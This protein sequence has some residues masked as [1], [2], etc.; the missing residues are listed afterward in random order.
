MEIINNLQ[1]QFG[2]MS[3]PLFICSALTLAIILERLL[4]VAL[5][6]S[7]GSKAIYRLLKEQNR[8][9]EQALTLFCKALSNKRPLLNKGIAMLIGHRHFNK[10]LRE[11]AAAIWLNQKRVQ[12]RSGL[13]LLALIG[14]IS[15]LLGLL[16]TVLGLIDMFKSV[17]ASTG[18]ITPNDLATGLGLAMRTTAAGLMVALPAISAA[19]LLG[20]W[21]DGVVRKLE[22][23]MNYCNLWLDGIDLSMQV[24]EMP[25]EEKHQLES[26]L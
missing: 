4:Q 1:A 8:D 2:L 19:Q 24:K 18:A 6:S 13:K 26:A 10:T 11:D 20:L 14:V 5:N 23:S 21:A 17:A 25:T 7:V 12:L 3:W 15:P 16:G 9:D 22:H